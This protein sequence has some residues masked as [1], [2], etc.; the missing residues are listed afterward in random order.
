M[1][2]AGDS[3]SGP[4]FYLSAP[5]C[6]LGAEPVDCSEQGDHICCN[7]VVAAQDSG[8]K[9]AGVCECVYVLG[10]DRLYLRN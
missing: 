9:S 10:G 4:S 6:F 2:R 5:R 7:V 1:V 8:E 3:V